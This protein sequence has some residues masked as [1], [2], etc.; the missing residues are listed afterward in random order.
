MA[1]LREGVRRALCAE[2][3]LPPLQRRRQWW[4]LVLSHWR[5]LVQ[6]ELGG[7]VGGAL[8]EPSRLRFLR[9]SHEIAR[10]LPLRVILEKRFLSR[11]RVEGGVDD[12]R[13]RVPLPLMPFLMT[14]VVGAQ[15]SPP[16]A[17]LVS[18]VTSWASERQPR[19]A[20]AA[21]WAGGRV[22]LER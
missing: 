1:C 2:A 19:R 8:R 9:L 18:L 22:H 15:C 4:P 14:E 12:D 13:R 7:A 21:P 17:R 5:Q 11:G 10:A 6:G 20:R 16:S 3:R